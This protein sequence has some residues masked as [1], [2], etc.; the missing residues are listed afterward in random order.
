MTARH[1][2]SE[3][4]DEGMEARDS[5]RTKHAADADDTTCA[6]PMPIS[7]WRT[8]CGGVEFDDEFVGGDPICGVDVTTY[9]ADVGSRAAASPSAGLARGITD[10]DALLSG[11]Q[12]PP[13]ALARNITN[14]A[15]LSSPLGA[16]HTPSSSKLICS[17]VASVRGKVGILH[18]EAAPN[19]GAKLR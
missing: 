7:T 8:L 19:L 18:S 1:I 15:G 10:L 6:P 3:L 14:V 9:D 5:V 17:P 12:S 2:A 13:A 16:L 4:G 11:I